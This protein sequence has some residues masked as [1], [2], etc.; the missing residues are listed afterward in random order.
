MARERASDDRLQQLV[1]QALHHDARLQASSIDV[2]V[3]RG[4]VLLSG[5]VADPQTHAIAV[6]VAQRI[7]G[8]RD[9]VDRISVRPFVPRFDADITADVVSAI[10]QNTSAN[11][12]RIDVVTTD[13]VV[14]LRGTVADAT[15]RQLVDSI[16]R[17]VDG[18][19]DV[20]DA[21]GI[22]PP[23]PHPDVEIAQTIRERLSKTLQPEAAAKIHVDVKEGIAYLDGEVETVALR[24]A[25]EDLVRWTSGVIDLVDR[26]RGPTAQP[27]KRRRQ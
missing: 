1:Q 26:L 6:A 2:S 20:V 5:L 27:L 13:G 25:I 10:T 9:V 3:D 4:T 16:A 7:R 18:V 17:S 21:L 23:V 14:Q 15:T 12:A 22:E 8:V 24:W 19:R 11:P